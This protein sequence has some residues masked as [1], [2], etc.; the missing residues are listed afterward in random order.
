MATGIDTNANRGKSVREVF[1][2]LD[3]TILRIHLK[4]AELKL[5]EQQE[6]I[7][8]CEELLGRKK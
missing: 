5:M 2:N 1:A 3:A 8:V 6:I 4:N 7:D